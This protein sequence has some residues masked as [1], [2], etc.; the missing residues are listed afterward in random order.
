[1]FPLSFLLLAPLALFEDEYGQQE[2]GAAATDEVGVHLG[3]TKT[4]GRD[5]DVRAAD[6]RHEEG[7]NERNQVGE[8]FALAR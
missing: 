8:A 1:M 3:Q 6:G 7:G 5:A 4:F 2:Q